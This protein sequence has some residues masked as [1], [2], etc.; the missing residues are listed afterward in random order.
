M[1]AVAELDEKQAERNKSA[2]CQQVQLSLQIASADKNLPNESQLSHWANHC[3][4]ELDVRYAYPPQLTIRIVDKLES[5]ELN[6]QWRTQDHATNVLSFPLD[7]PPGVPESC[8]GD[9]VLCAE[10]IATEAQTQHKPLLAHWAHMILHGVLH[11]LGYDHIDVAEA[12]IM[13]ELEIRMMQQ[14]GYS[15]PY[16]DKDV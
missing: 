5:R 3:L 7:M 16:Q 11:L 6:Q 1:N 13:E 8:L 9:L 10:V 4:S 2:R 14:L 15:N 12:Q